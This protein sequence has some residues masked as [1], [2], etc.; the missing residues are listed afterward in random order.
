MRQLATIKKVDNITPIEGADRIETATIGGW[1]VVVN[2]GIFKPGDLGIYFEIDSFLPDEPEY[3]F[4]KDKKSFQGKEGY[5]LRTVKLRKQISQGLFLPISDFAIFDGITLIEGQDVSDTLNIVKYEKPLPA[6]LQGKAKGNFPSF[7]PKTD[8]ERVQNISMDELRKYK[9][10]WFVETLKID[11]SSMTVYLKGNGD[12][13]TTG[14]CSRNLDLIETEGNIYW[15]LT[16]QYAILERLKT[17][18]SKYGRSYAIQGEAYGEGIQS[19]R[20]KVNGRK[21]AIYNIFQIDDQKYLPV[22]DVLDIITEL[23][24]YNI[25]AIPLE[26]VPITRQ[27]HL[28]DLLELSTHDNILFYADVKHD[29]HPVPLEGFVYKN[30]SKTIDKYSFKVI[31]NQYLL[32]LGE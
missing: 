32:K 12:D 22:Q 1:K 29:A 18:Y 13:V 31:S 3:S 19:N 11:G 24:T 15:E 20:W 26:Y 21:F 25:D 16:K 4:L 10:D 9:D 8:E 30:D 5:R 28:G 7:I 17:L 27:A 23:N 2:K 14:V 6:Q